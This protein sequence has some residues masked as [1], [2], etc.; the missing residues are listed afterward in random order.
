LSRP[1]QSC[2]DG[3][4][5][6]GMAKQKIISL[7]PQQGMF[8]RPP[9]SIKRVLDQGA[10]P[11]KLKALPE[12]GCR[13]QGLFVRGLEPVDSGLYQTLDRVRNGAVGVLLRI[14]Q[15]LLQKQRIAGGAFQAA[16]GE[17]THL[18]EDIAGERQRLVTM[19][20]C[21][22]DRQDRSA[23]LPS[24]CH[25]ITDVARGEDE[26]QRAVTRRL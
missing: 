23:W 21:E 11:A 14:A 13:L 19:Q 18:L 3:V 20:R 10:Q 4:P 9:G 7:W 16:H 17:R 12:H 8:Y 6:K 2:V 22:I 24:A 1:E 15:Q 26:Q 5:D 25:R